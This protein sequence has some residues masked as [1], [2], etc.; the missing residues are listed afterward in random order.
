VTG[1][2]LSVNVSTTKGT[3]KRP[4]DHALIDGNGIAGDAHAGPWHRQVSI[5]GW[6]S[7]ERFAAREGRTFAPGDFAENLTLSGIRTGQVMLLDRFR[8]GTVEL[9]VTQIGKSCHAA[10]CTVSQ[11]VGRCVMPQEGIFCRV[12]SGGT[13][14]AGDPVDHF[15]RTLTCRVITL[16]DRAFAGQYP[17][18]SG[19]M[20]S[21][22]LEA[23]FQGKR[24]DLRIERAVL[25]DD[26]GRLRAELTAAC[27]AGT[28]V[29]FTTGGTG[30]GPRDITPETVVEV[31]HKLIPGIMEN[32]R[33][34]FASE[35]PNALLSRSVA[36]VAGTTQVYALPGSVQAVTE[37]MG[38]IL[39]TLEHVLF[40][41]HG[42]D[43]HGRGG[44]AMQEGPFSEDCSTDDERK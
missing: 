17:D 39:K 43:V 28:D 42:L 32:I 16:S 8:I 33:I 20:V 4:V 31:C 15:P 34:K 3:P 1:K 9:V 37:Y 30:L 14:R 26:P 27:K 2:V 13:V 19:P 22:M 36:G 5:L 24:W 29:V 6:E 12:L 35:K 40:M 10:G 23:F 11:L 38:E 7:I 18:R 44:G 21:R 25:P 41:I